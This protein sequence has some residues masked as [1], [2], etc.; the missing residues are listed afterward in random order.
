MPGLEM[1]IP[2][3]TEMLTKMWQVDHFENNSQAFS[4]SSQLNIILHNGLY[5]SHASALKSFNDAI[6]FAKKYPCRIIVLC[7]EKAREDDIH[8]TGKLF[9]Q[10]YIGDNIREQCC[11]EALILGYTTDD[12]IFLKDQVSLWLES[13]LP[14]YYWVNEISPGAIKKHYL[15]LAELCSKVIYDS[16]VEPEGFK[17]IHWS[18]HHSVTDLAFMRLLPVRQSLGQFLSGYSE[19][20]L[21]NGLE[22]VVVEY[23]EKL[24]AEGH[25]LLDWFRIALEKCA[26]CGKEKIEMEFVLMESLE[27]GS[28]L[29]AQWTYKLNK[30]FEWEYDCESGISEVKSKFDKEIIGYPLQ[31]RRMSPAEALAAAVFY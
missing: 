9:S 17:D 24:S 18:E 23:S 3:V 25:Q 1:P 4:R 30:F 11:C 16:A 8:L 26:E 29:K 14:S 19:E 28:F 27:E 7:P 31:L 21:I 15:S 5:A 12:A 2:Q 10:C 20:V 13:D 22:K 6:D